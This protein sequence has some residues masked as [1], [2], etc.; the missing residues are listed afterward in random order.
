MESKTVLEH[1]PQPEE[2][3]VF[4][5]LAQRMMDNDHPVIPTPVEELS[6]LEALYRRH[7]KA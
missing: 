5:E 1:S 4:R 3:E 2:A 7:L 6:E